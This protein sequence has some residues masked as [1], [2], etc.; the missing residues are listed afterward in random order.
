[1]R[2]SIINHQYFFT[3]QIMKTKS[4]LLINLL[5]MLISCAEKGPFTSNKVDVSISVSQITCKTA[6]V[7]FHQ[8]HDNYLVNYI[9]LV[10]EDIKENFDTDN[11]IQGAYLYDSPVYYKG[12]YF[13]YDLE[14]NSKYKV[15][16]DIRMVDEDVTFPF[17]TGYSF[18]TAPQGDWS[19][20]DISC[21]YHNSNS[22]GESSLEVNLPSPLEYHSGDF[23]ASLSSD[24]S[25][26]IKSNWVENDDGSSLIVWFNSLENKEYFIEFRGRLK[27][28]HYDAFL[29]L[30]L[31]L[32]NSV[33]LSD[34]N[35]KETQE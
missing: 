17:D 11:R 31:K 19:A 16:S 13:F 29:D 18:T 6:Y 8:D 34:M 14:P 5:L 4:F 21:V 26:P 7:S 33:D 35:V 22:W 28:K 2:M 15:Y 10:K 9:Y 3:S 25:N 32:N 12:T 1:M 30:T 24:M 20:L 27:I 23:Y